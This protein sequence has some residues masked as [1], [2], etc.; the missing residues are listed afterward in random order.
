MISD[1][2]QAI[3]D[4]SRVYPFKFLTNAGAILQEFIP[5][6]TGYLTRNANEL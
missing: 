6:N 5:I 4:K 2:G 3:R 1:R